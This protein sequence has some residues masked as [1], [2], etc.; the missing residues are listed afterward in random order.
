MAT[1]GSSWKDESED[2]ALREEYLNATGSQF[3][4]S[5][6]ELRKEIDRQLDN[7]TMLSRTERSRLLD[8]SEKLRPKDE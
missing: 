6:D 8:L 5:A 3:Y 4:G 7:G 1:F 2:D